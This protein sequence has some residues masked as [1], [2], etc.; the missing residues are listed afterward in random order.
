[1][2]KGVPVDTTVSAV[3]TAAAGTLY[4]GLTL[5]DWAAMMTIAASIIASLAVLVRLY[6]GW[7]DRKNKK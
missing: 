2:T 3:A 6:W 7:S 4:L 5:T 1:M